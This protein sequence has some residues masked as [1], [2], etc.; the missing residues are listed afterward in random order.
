MKPLHLALTISLTSP[1]MYLSCSSNDSS[2]IPVEARCGQLTR[3]E[4][5]S[6]GC[7]NFGLSELG[8]VYAIRPGATSIDPPISTLPTTPIADTDG[9]PQVCVELLE[10]PVRTIPST[11]TSSLSYRVE[12]ET[13]FTADVPETIQAELKFLLEEELTVRAEIVRTR[14]YDNLARLANCSLSLIDT[15]KQRDNPAEDSF[16]MISEVRDVA[17][18]AIMAGTSIQLNTEVTYSV[19]SFTFSVRYTCDEAVMISSQTSGQGVPALAGVRT[20]SFDPLQ[21]TFTEIENIGCEAIFFE[22]L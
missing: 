17:N 22:D 4:N 14:R 13:Q 15:I 9:L 2:T 19:S 7:L 11:G 6:L 3:F 16:V 12:W 8:S 20:L 1:I 5:P 21:E 18:F 10:N